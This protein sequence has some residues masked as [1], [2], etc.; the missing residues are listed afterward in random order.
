MNTNEEQKGHWLHKESSEI[1]TSLRVHP[2]VDPDSDSKPYE[3]SNERHM[4]LCSEKELK[5]Q[6]VKL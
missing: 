3:L 6:F 5:E 2:I 4:R 1:F